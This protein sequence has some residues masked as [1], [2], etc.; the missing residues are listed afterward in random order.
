[1]RSNKRRKYKSKLTHLQENYTKCGQDRN[2]KEREPR[3]HKK[4][5]AMF[6]QQKILQKEKKRKRK[7]DNQL[8]GMCSSDSDDSNDG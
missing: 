6:Q 1:M 3:R 4:R 2:I 5:N 8:C 7:N